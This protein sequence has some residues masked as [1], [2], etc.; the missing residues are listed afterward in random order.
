MADNFRDAIHFVRVFTS[1]PHHIDP[2]KFGCLHLCDRRDANP[3]C[4]TS[5]IVIA[6]SG[7]NALPVSKCLKS[8]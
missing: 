1:I 7:R 4:H 6:E 2:L 3:Q 5:D 8:P